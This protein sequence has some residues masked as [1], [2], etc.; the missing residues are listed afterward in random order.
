MLD[1]N[2]LRFDGLIRFAIALCLAAG[3][4]FAVVWLRLWHGVLTLN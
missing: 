4:V 3:F 2:D 1:S